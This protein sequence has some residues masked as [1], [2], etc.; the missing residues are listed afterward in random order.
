MSHETA[1][2]QQQ[3]TKNSCWQKSSQSCPNSED[4]GLLSTLARTSAAICCVPMSKCDRRCQC[5]LN[6]V[7]CKYCQRISL[8]EQLSLSVSSGLSFPLEASSLINRVSHNG[9]V[10][11]HPSRQQRAGQLTNNA[12]SPHPNTELMGT[13]VTFRVTLWLGG[14]LQ[15]EAFYEIY[16]QHRHPWNILISSTR[17]SVLNVLPLSCEGRISF[18]CREGV[19][20]NKLKSQKVTPVKPK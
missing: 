4:L 5:R 19:G 10:H 7:S 13:F 8:G 6:A 15:G 9:S 2:Q 1:W 14:W 16:W 12:P 11:K 20:T 18:L 17:V 3:N